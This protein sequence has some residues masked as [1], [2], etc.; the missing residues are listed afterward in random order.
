MIIHHQRSPPSLY[1]PPSETPSHISSMRDAWSKAI[2]GDVEKHE[3][4]KRLKKISKNRILRVADYII[5][6]YG[7]CLTYSMYKSLVLEKASPEEWD[8][9]RGALRLKESPD[10]WRETAETNAEL[11]A[12]H[13][14][15]ISILFADSLCDNSSQ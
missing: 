7:S 4:V 9:M 14:L 5:N 12:Y 15:T 3:N 1:R 11:L 8:R 10:G 6:E 13:R 2:G